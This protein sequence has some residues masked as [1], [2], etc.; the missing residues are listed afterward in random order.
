MRSVFHTDLIKEV[1]FQKSMIRDF[2]HFFRTPIFQFQHVGLC[3]T[4]TLIKLFFEIGSENLENDIFLNRFLRF[5]LRIDPRDLFEE[6]RCI[7]RD[8]CSKCRFE[9]G[10]Q[11][12]EI[13]D[14]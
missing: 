12:S 5:R 14:S 6:M 10:S 13:D 8:E 2:K 4:I 1:N 3:T 11:F 9:E 7:T